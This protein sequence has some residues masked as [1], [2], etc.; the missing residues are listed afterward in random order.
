MCQERS[1]TDLQPALVNMSVYIYDGKVSQSFTMEL[2][3]STETNIFFPFSQS[4]CAF[5]EEMLL[6]TSQLGD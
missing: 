4:S 5:W 6:L 3:K 1:L 2:A